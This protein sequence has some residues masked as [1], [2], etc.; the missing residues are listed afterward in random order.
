MQCVGYIQTVGWLKDDVLPETLSSLK[1]VLPEK[2][3]S[4]TLHSL[5][6]M[7]II[8]PKPLASLVIGFPDLLL[9]LDSLKKTDIISPPD[10]VLPEHFRTLSSLNNFR[11]LSSLN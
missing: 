10:I 3:S 9:V 7:V 6:Q 5:K 2:K 8:T 1:L 11:T 4:Q